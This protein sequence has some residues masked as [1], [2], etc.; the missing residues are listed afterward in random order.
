VQGHMFLQHQELCA[1]I[2]AVHFVTLS[3][4]WNACLYY[5][6]LIKLSSIIL[7]SVLY[8]SDIENY[9]FIL[10]SLLLIFG[11]YVS[12]AWT[13]N[14]LLPIHIRVHISQ[15]S[16]TILLPTYPLPCVVKPNL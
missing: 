15:I 11:F 2:I 9:P 1:C 5:W 13:F 16:K 4:S 3:K 14:F 7:L 10:L 12:S 8:M 6:G